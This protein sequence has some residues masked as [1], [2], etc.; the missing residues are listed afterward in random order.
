MKNILSYEKINYYSESKIKLLMRLCQQSI[1]ELVQEKEKI[2]TDNN[3]FV[4]RIVLPIIAFGAGVMSKELTGV[5]MIAICIV[6]LFFVVMINFSAK[7]ISAFEDIEGGLIEER[8]YLY[9]KLRDLL[10]R[11]FEVTNLDI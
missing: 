3:M 4:Q 6:A 8:K 10:I 1:N 7:E 9:E 2:R 5:E 11:D